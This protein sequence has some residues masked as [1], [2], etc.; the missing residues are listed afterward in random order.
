MT[1]KS[2]YLYVILLVLV[3]VYFIYKYNSSKNK[4]VEGY[5]NLNLP[6]FNEFMKYSQ[7]YQ[8]DENM[9]TIAS[10]IKDRYKVKSFVMNIPTVLEKL[11]T[12]FIETPSINKPKSENSQQTI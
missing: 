2:H 8:C 5:K 10:D 1:L 7:G 12:V 4:T 6:S 3:S 9:D 11:S